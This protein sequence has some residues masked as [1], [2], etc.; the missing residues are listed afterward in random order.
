MTPP[1]SAFRQVWAMPIMLGVLTLAGLVV[2]LLADGVWDDLAAAALA[3]PVLAGAWHAL[4]PAR[5]PR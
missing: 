5:S 1:A 4:R 3:L 2:G